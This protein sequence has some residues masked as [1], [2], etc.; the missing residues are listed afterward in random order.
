MV[1]EDRAL[2]R[3]STYIM[4]HFPTTITYIH[5]VQYRW[6]VS[7]LKVFLTSLS[8]SLVSSDAPTGNSRYLSTLK[9][10]HT[11]CAV[12]CLISNNSDL[13][14][15]GFWP[16]P[17]TSMTSEKEIRNFCSSDVILYRTE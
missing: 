7:E 11:Q 2:L 3:A 17:V 15:D 9:E 10:T 12:S 14:V 16:I 6:E 5:D 8:S 13:S 4:R 1:T